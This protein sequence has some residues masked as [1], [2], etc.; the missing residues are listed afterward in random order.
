MH[1]NDAGFPFVIEHWALD[2]G[3]SP[4]SRFRFPAAPLTPTD[5]AARMPDAAR[6]GG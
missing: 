5:A 3:H 6:H 4:F 2:I 1:W